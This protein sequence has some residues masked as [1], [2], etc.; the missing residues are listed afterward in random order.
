MK[1]KDLLDNN[2]KL[3]QHKIEMSLNIIF[4]AHFNIQVITNNIISEYQ[5]IDYLQLQN[6]DTIILVINYN[7]IELKISTLQKQR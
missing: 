2:N 6:E 4:N 3:Y 7:Q 5:Q 1:I